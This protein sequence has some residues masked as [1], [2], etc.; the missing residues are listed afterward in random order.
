MRHFINPEISELI[1]TQNHSV[2]SYFEPSA[3]KNEY[4][5][6]P[7]KMQYMHIK[8][9]E[10][11]IIQTEYNYTKKTAQFYKNEIIFVNR[12]PAPQYNTEYYKY[13]WSQFH[14]YAFQTFTNLAKNVIADLVI[15]R[16]NEHFLFLAIDNYKLKS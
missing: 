9:K 15:V 10:D 5:L 11:S 2:L 1:K 12:G 14:Q 4:L 16:N 7:G 8:S 13:F 3:F 6:V